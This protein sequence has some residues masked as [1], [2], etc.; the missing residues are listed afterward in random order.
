M[1]GFS[2]NAQQILKEGATDF[3]MK[4]FDLNELLFKLKLALG[5]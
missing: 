3:I 4:P 5:Q 1:S 2:L